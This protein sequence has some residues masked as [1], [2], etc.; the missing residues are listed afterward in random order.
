MPA[1]NNIP[2][3]FA[4]ARL[5]APDGTSSTVN[6]EAGTTLEV[7]LQQ[8]GINP[9]DVTA[10]VDRQTVPANTP[11]QNGQTVSATPNKVNGAF[12]RTR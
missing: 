5:I 8:Q 1:N 3:G 6:F 4:Q 2:N 9:A 12:R 11:V 7:F 10:R